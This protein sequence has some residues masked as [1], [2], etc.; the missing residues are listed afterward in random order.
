MY[1][2]ILQQNTLVEKSVFKDASQKWIKNKVIHEKLLSIFSLFT[3]KSN[4]C[5]ALATRNLLTDLPMFL[6]KCKE[7]YGTMSDTLPTHI[8]VWKLHAHWEESVYFM[9]VLGAAR[10]SLPKVLLIKYCCGLFLSYGRH[11]AQIF[12][13][14]I[15]QIKMVHNRTYI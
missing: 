1:D 10:G 13:L 15:G 8:E 14:R 6:E 9:L 11:S 4:S 5:S 12:T 2:F 7:I 3:L